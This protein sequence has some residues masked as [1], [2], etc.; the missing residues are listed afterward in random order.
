MTPSAGAQVLYKLVDPQGRVTYS[1]REPKNFDGKVIRL[2]PDVA[3]NVVPS[4]KA[5]ESPA[6][7]A[8]KPGL[9]E[10]RRATRED[11]EK[12]LRAAQSRYEAARK[13]K[14]DGASPAPGEMQVVQRRYAPLAAGQAPPRPNCFPSVDPN[15]AS[16]LICPMQVPQEAYF[17]RLKKL[18]EELARAEEELQLAERAYR[19]GTD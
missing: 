15:G 3:S 14:E 4:A 12:K 11:L 13:A 7:G 1:D 18:D 5:G 19:R 8:P 6:K 17:D 16:L 9:A 2:E 10:T